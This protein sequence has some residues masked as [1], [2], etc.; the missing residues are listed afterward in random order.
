MG[1][2]TKSGGGILI[3]VLVAFII[4]ALI[5]G[6]L[7]A[8][9]KYVINQNTEGGINTDGN[10]ILLTRAANI[11]DIEINQDVEAS[12]FNLKDT[13]VLIPKVDINNL[14]VTFAYYDD[15]DNF[16]KT[17]EYNFGNVKKNV[18][19]EASISHTVT[20]LFTITKVQYRVSGGSVSY[21]AS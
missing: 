11:S 2:G 15:S 6:G 21:F 19:Y 18:S 16:I 20:E 17:R 12:I 5:F 4:S 10:P 3:K 13:Y 8:I 1:K 7:V 9:V 14:T